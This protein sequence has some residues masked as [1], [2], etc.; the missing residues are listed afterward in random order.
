M[1]ETRIS[2]YE[3][4]FLFPQ[5]ASAD[6][7]AAV[8][9]ITEIL[10]RGHVEIVALRKWD[11]RR[12]AYDIHGNKRGVYFLAYFKAETSALAGI[13]RDLRLSEKLLRSLITKAN[14]VMPE[15]IAAAEGRQQIDDEIK[16]RAAQPAAAAPA[17]TDA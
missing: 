11:E 8:A 13:E 16:L 12:L 9:H 6:L 14:H 17:A 15:E 10:Q 5:S 4:L 1:T 3:G 7:Q 2:M